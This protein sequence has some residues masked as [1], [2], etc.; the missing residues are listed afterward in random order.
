MKF[1]DIKLLFVN[2]DILLIDAS[3]TEIIKV[4][5]KTELHNSEYDEYYVDQIEVG[6][7]HKAVEIQIYN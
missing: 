4:L 3:T 5:L 6:E 2:T 1:K 7:Q